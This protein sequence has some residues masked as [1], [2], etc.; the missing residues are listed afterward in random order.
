MRLKKNMKWN[1]FYK[2]KRNGLFSQTA[3]KIEY[4]S[5]NKE[6]FFIGNIK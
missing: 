3:K 4:F 2:N 1:Q 5:K 6:I